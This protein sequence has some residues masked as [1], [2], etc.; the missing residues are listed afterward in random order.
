M[1]FVT[2]GFCCVEENPFGPVQLNVYPAGA[3]PL[4]KIVL[5][6]QTT[7]VD[8]EAVM[9]TAGGKADDVFSDERRGVPA[10]I[11]ACTRSF[12]P[13]VNM[14]MQPSST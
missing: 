7:G 13:C 2:E 3:V 8:V 9:A 12:C 14:N 11:T 10:P 4:R 1:V 6:V 5:P